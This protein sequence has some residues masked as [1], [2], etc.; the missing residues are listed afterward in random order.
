MA[1]FDFDFLNMDGGNH[2]GGNNLPPSNNL[3]SGNN[4]PH[5]NP[6]DITAAAAGGDATNNNHPAGNN[7]QALIIYL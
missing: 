6:G 2:P 3:P 1:I 5:N 4:N 7:L